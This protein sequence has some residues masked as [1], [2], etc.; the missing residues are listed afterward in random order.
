MN[1]TFLAYGNRPGERD[2]AAMM[3]ASARKCMPGLRIV[4]ATDADTEAF[5]GVDAVKRYPVTPLPPFTLLTGWHMIQCERDT[6]YADTDIIFRADIRNLFEQ[7]FDA[8]L[9]LREKND[10]LYVEQRYCGGIILIRN[11]KFFTDV[12]AEVETMGFQYQIWYAGQMAFPKVALRGYKIFELPMNVYNYA[13]S[14]DQDSLP[15][16]AKVIHFK[17]PKRKNFMLEDKFGLMK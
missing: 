11:Q 7:D 13:P 8:G 5:E 16:S 9:C 3:I 2:M 4:Q 10:P 17:G 1:L 6:I 15:D 12:Y 14:E